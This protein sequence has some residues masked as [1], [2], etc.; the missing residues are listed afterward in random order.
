MC[1]FK[2]YK[3]NSKQYKIIFISNLSRKTNFTTEKTHEELYR[4]NG[5]FM[6]VVDVKFND[7]GNSK[8]L[9]ILFLNF[10]NSGYNILKCII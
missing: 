9:F 2:E 1:S 10:Q 7:N 8:K 3:T 4:W 5:H 6:G